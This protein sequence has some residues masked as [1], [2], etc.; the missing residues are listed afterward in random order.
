MDTHLS[1]GKSFNLNDYT[2]IFFYKML[3]FNVLIFENIRLF[4]H[5]GRKCPAVDTY[6][7]LGYGLINRMK[8]VSSG[9]YLFKINPVGQSA[10]PLLSPIY[11][12]TEQFLD[13]P[14]QSKLLILKTTLSRDLSSFTKI[15]PSF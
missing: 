2:N 13:Q 11:F 14:K 5:I 8:S 4:G 10:Q 1:K 6:F 7:Q 9:L 3:F 15:K 12:R